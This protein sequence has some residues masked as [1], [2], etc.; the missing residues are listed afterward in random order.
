MI[1]VYHHVDLQKVAITEIHFNILA[2]LKY[3]PDTVTALLLQIA[4]CQPKKGHNR[5]FTEG[6]C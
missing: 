4:F 2:T 5:I 3:C 1:Q 6:H